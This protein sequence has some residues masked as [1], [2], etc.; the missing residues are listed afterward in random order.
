MRSSGVS[1]RTAEVIMAVVFFGV[2]AVMMVDTWQLGA[3]WAKEG[4]QSGYFPFRIGAII[5]LA[6]IAVIVQALRAKDKDA[7][8][9]TY[10]R[11]KLVLRVLVPTLV[12]VAAIHLIGIYVAS[13]IFI[14][15]FMRVM[16][17]YSWVKTLAVSVGLNAIFFWL[18]EVQFLVPLPKGPLET[19][20][21]Y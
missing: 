3:G 6:S 15:G 1:Q 7:V 16:D 18:F 14:A 17:K 19:W 4:P 10:D 8:F 9:V 11:L 21:G 12:Y 20:F 2:G 5:C 13:A